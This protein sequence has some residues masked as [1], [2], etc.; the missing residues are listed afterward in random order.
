MDMTL[1]D[2]YQKHF[3]K[4]TSGTTSTW[5]RIKKWKVLE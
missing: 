4:N 5:M 3:F 1:H 2:N